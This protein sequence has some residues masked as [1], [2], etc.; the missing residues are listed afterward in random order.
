MGKKSSNLRWIFFKAFSV[1]HYTGFPEWIVNRT[2]LE[3]HYKGVKLH[4]SS[5][6]NGANLCLIFIRSKSKM[7]PGWRTSSSSYRGNSWRNFPL[8]EW[9]MSL[10]GQ[11][12]QQT[13]MLFTHFKPMPLVSCRREGEKAV[14]RKLSFSQ[15]FLFSNII[16]LD[17]WS[18]IIDEQGGDG[19]TKE[20]LELLKSMTVRNLLN[21]IFLWIDKESTK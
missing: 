7:T 12:V 18:F 10:T 9:R 20:I 17:W 14:I 21:E 15:F 13:W 11:R 1:F 8:G 2:R 5:L 6:V 16:R 4:R 3:H 19:Q